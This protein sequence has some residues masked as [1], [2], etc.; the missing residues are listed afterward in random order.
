LDTEIIR[1]KHAGVQQEILDQ[2]LLKSWRLL[3]NPSLIFSQCLQ[4]NLRPFFWDKTDD[5]V[6]YSLVRIN[7]Y[8]YIITLLLLFNT[9]IVI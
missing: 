3:I 2:L 5:Y 7:I 1:F 4:T 8:I 6:N 9:Y